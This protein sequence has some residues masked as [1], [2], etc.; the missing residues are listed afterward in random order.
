MQSFKIKVIPPTSSSLSSVSSDSNKQRKRRKKGK[1]RR[2]RQ[3]CGCPCALFC[4][5]SEDDKFDTKRKALHGVSPYEVSP[6]HH[7]GTS[8]NSNNNCPSLKSCNKIRHRHQFKHCRFCDRVHSSKSASNSTNDCHHNTKHC[9]PCSSHSGSHSRGSGGTSSS[10]TVHA[11]FNRPAN[12]PYKYISPNRTFEY[13]R[14]GPNYGCSTSLDRAYYRYHTPPTFCSPGGKIKASSC[15]KPPPNRTHASC[16]NILIATLNKEND[17]ISVTKDLDQQ[18]GILRIFTRSRWKRNSKR[19]TKRSTQQCSNKPPPILD[20]S[21]LP[22][23]SSDDYNS[24]HN[25]FV[26]L[27]KH[28][29][30]SFLMRDYIN[31]EK[32][33]VTRV[34]SDYSGPS[35]CYSF[36]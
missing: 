14:S 11:V 25:N 10:T 8:D 28:R 31:D 32:T 21:L 15:I 30:K 19:R 35:S 13:H 26:D 3:K 24:D 5:S 6:G 23:D 17:N 4:V 9:C 7:H 12:N 18:C 36:V 1:H 27:R 34:V 2:C 33:V 29:S 20:E 22:G 16:D